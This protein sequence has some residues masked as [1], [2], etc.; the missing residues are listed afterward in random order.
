MSESVCNPC[1]PSIERHHVNNRLRSSRGS[2]LI[3]VKVSRIKP[4]DSSYR[5][6]R[7]WDQHEAALSQS[8]LKYLEIFLLTKFEVFHVFKYVYYIWLHGKYYIWL[9]SLISSIY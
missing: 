9:M 3:S 5:P 1:L 4:T 7:L 8:H 2:L 6:L